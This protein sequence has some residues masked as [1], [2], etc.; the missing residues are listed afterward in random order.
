M[1]TGIIEWC[2]DIKQF[3]FIDQEDGPETLV[4]HPNINVEISKP[5]QT[6]PSG[7]LKSA[8]EEM[9]YTPIKQIREDLLI[10]KSELAR[11]AGISP[12]TIDRIENGMHCRTNTKRKIILALGY[13]L[14]E[15]S[16]IF[17]NDQI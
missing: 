2:S 17:P 10:S 5:S 11:K 1:A 12:R 7:N 9:G 13:D 6:V 14:S 3:R 4:Q 16:K 8:E 15:S